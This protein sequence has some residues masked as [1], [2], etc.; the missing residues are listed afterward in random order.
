MP[1]IFDATAFT[2]SAVAAAGV[3]NSAASP[4]GKTAPAMVPLLMAASTSSLAI[5]PVRASSL[6]LSPLSVAK[7]AFMASAVSLLSLE[8]ITVSSDASEPLRGC[9]AIAEGIERLRGARHANAHIAGAEGR[10]LAAGLGAGRDLPKVR[11]SR[12]L[13]GIDLG[14]STHQH[15]VL[16][17]EVPLVERPH[18]VRAG[19]AVG[20]VEA[21]PQAIES[22]GRLVRGLEQIAFLAAA[23]DTSEAERDE[24]ARAP[25]T[26]RCFRSVP[27]YLGLLQLVVKERGS[28]DRLR[29]Q[30]ERLGLHLRRAGDAVHE[31]LAVD[32]GLRGGPQR[33]QIAEELQIGAL[34]G[35]QERHLAQH[36]RRAILALHLVAT[37]SGHHDAV[38]H[39]RAC[40]S[41]VEAKRSTEQ[42]QLR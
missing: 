30:R 9:K 35:G 16:H 11:G 17:D 2:P 15:H 39:R 37:A 38:A 12:G 1:P 3:P 13:D 14:T 24:S 34:R 20:G 18:G 42:R 36:V 19:D 21:V 25:E 23:K 41:V 32:G 4:A 10:G 33:F 28:H 40:R 29:K 22:E 26:P 6:M 27:L 31:V 7:A 8:P 5:A